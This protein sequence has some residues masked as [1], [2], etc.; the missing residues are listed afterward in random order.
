MTETYSDVETLLAEIRERLDSIDDGNA[1]EPETFTDSEREELHELVGEARTMTEKSTLSDLFDSVDVDD[2]PDTVE[3]TDVPEL[4]GDASAESILRLRQL[5][6]LKRIDE[7]WTELSDEERWQQLADVSEFDSQVEAETGED[8]TGSRDVENGAEDEKERADDTPDA[9]TEP[10]GAG[11]QNEETSQDEQSSVREFSDLVDEVRARFIDVDTTERASN[12]STDGPEEST[13]EPEESTDEPEESA[14]EAS[15]D[16]T[17]SDRQ[18][19]TG[20][21]RHRFSTVPSQ[22]RADMSALS[23]RSFR[24]RP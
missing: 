24:Y 6:E 1:D 12:E 23:R 20:S 13:D 2:V 4:V 11:E 19:D 21:A 3:P 5:L 14:D 18:T 22:N 8:P 10:A 16:E 15:A 17:S 9:T 7:H